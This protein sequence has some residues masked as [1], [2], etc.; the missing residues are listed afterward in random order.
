MSEDCVSV[1]S[2]YQ[3]EIDELWQPMRCHEPTAEMLIALRGIRGR[4][5]SRLEAIYT[6]RRVIRYQDHT[7]Y[8]DSS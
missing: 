3:Q 4:G 8:L 5:Y 7:V 1:R 2:G 6:C